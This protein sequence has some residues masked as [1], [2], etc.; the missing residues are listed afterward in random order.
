M[1]IALMIILACFI[2]VTNALNNRRA[3]RL[4]ILLKNEQATND[5]TT[6]NFHYKHYPKYGYVVLITSVA[7]NN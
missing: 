1:I 4:Y 2:P 5:F 6:D 7:T 3:Q